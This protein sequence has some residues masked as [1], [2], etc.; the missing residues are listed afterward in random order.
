MSSFM[1]IGFAVAG[2]GA[3]LA[4][5][6]LACRRCL[7]CFGWAMGIFFF[8]AQQPGLSF[9]IAGMVEGIFMPSCIGIFMPSCMGMPAMPGIAS[10]FSIMP[11]DG[12]ALSLPG[13]DDCVEAC[14]AICPWAVAM[15]GDS[16][17]APTSASE[18]KQDRCDLI[19]IYTPSEWPRARIEPQ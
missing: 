12:I 11:P 15:P 19:I 1:G 2:I 16:K 3:G 8:M 14:P 5:A 9:A 18:R 7:A 6:G 17:I 13:M 10:L 4:A